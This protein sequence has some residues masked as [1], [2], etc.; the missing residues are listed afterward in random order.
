MTT[1]LRPAIEGWFTT[2]DEPA[3]LG[4]RCRACGSAFFPREAGFCRN[5]GCDGDELDE[6]ELSRTGRVWSYTDARYQP[7]PPYIPRHAEGE[8]YTPFAIAAVELE[9][10][11]MVV[12]GQVADGYGVDDLSIGAEVELVVEPLHTDGDTTFLTWRWRPVR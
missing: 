10:E 7:P 4:T 5:P 8:E 2:G 9:A 12:L 6:V 11:G 3:L 1:E